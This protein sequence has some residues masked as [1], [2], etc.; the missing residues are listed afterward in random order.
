M[1]D[2][3]WEIV[4]SL[5]GENTISNG[6]FNRGINLVQDLEENRMCVQKLLPPEPYHSGYVEREIRILKGIE[7][8]NILKLYG[9]DLGQHKHDIPWTC[10]EFCEGGTL[11]QAMKLYISMDEHFP[12]AFL[13]HLFESLAE[14]VR[15]CHN[16]SRKGE[17]GYIE[18]WDPVIHRDI[19]L[20]NIFLH[21][22]GET[23]TYAIVKLGDFGC[24]VTLGEVRAKKLMKQDLPAQDP[25]YVPPEGP[26][27]AQCCDIFQIGLV[28]MCFYTRVEKPDKRA[29][30]FE[31]DE[32]RYGY[33]NYSQKLRRLISSC[34]IDY[35][36]DQPSAEVLLES[37]RTTKA[38]MEQDGVFPLFEKLLSDLE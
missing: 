30:V 11:M 35:E 20:T 7:H 16:G 29:S 36:P 19:I 32:W 26:G 1:L 13:W 34:L 6:F 25:L 37:I 9:A 17:E 4:C 23:N 22:S 33:D 3:R 18:S 27:A 21:H 38:S 2:R 8:P 15:Y 12:E 31:H 14:A 10:T 28:M 5:T 24:A